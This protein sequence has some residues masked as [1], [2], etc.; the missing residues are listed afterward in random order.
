MKRPTL[1]LQKPQQ[2][3]DDDFTRHEFD[4]LLPYISYAF[5]S[6]S[7]WGPPFLRIHP[8]PR[9]RRLQSS[10]TRL[11]NSVYLR[12][13]C[14]L[15]YGTLIWSTPLTTLAFTTAYRSSPPS[16]YHSQPLI[17][18]LDLDYLIYSCLYYG[19][20]IWTT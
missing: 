2:K 1:L 17:R 5:Y 16:T 15:Y 7:T 18:H 13:Y 20:W 19:I 8:P 11:S 9:Y 6:M 12:T 3:S 4:S 14:C 10:K